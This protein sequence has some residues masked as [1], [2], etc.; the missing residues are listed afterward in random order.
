MLQQQS[1]EFCLFALICFSFSQSNCPS[2]GLDK[3]VVIFSVQGDSS[4]RLLWALDSAN[5]AMGTGCEHDHSTI[6]LI[7]Y[8]QIWLNVSLYWLSV[9]MVG[10]V[11]FYFQS[12]PSKCQTAPGWALQYSLSSF[13]CSLAPS[14]SRPAWRSQPSKLSFSKDH[15]NWFPVR[16]WHSSPLIY[17]RKVHSID[18]N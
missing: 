10:L 5:N 8:C 2:Q 11:M 18:S 7:F 14:L 1:W 16:V 12:V 3:V 6:M 15:K 4:S 17:L 13:L 9:V